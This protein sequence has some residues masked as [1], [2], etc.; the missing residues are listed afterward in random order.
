MSPQAQVQYKYLIAADGNSFPGSLKWQLFSGSVVLRNESPW[1]QWYENALIP[2]EHYI[3]YRSD[4]SDLIE[5]IE[6]L[7]ENDDRAQ[8][9]AIKAKEFARKNLNSKSVELYVYKLLKAYSRL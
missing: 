2:N 3:P 5:K 6:W 8:Q 4:C 1:V 9:M 7:K